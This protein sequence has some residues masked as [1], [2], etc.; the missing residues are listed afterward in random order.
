MSYASDCHKEEVDC[1]TTQTAQDDTA[2]AQD[3]PDMKRTSVN[4]YG[5][6]SIG[7]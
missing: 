1:V 2:G 7:L 3:E 5:M 6:V 4:R